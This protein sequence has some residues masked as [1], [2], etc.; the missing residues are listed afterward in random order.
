[1][2]LQSAFLATKDAFSPLI[3]VPLAAVTN[4]VLDL[5]LVGSLGLGTAGAVSGRTGAPTPA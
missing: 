5:F 1:M 4:L 3:A 2:V